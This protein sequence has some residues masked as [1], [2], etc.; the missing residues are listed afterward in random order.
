MSDMSQLAEFQIIPESA[1]PTLRAAAGAGKARWFST[2]TNTFW[3]ALERLSPNVLNLDWSGYT[4][5][6]LLNF[7]RERKGF[8]FSRI[9]AH[10]LGVFLSESQQCGFTVFESEVAAEFAS[11]L[12]A[13]LLSETEL[14]TY[15]TEFTGLDHPETGKAMLAAATALQKALAQVPSTSI[16][17]LH[18]G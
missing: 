18:I 6:V 8:D 11:K 13:T 17:L 14:A 5:F 9:D 16:G 15:S 2:P 10:P 3:D 12:A 7:L 4:L 1:V